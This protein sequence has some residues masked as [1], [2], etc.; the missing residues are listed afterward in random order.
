MG[1][2][3][4]WMLN[5]LMLITIAVVEKQLWAGFQSLMNEEE[6]EASRGWLVR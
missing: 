5:P 3:A 1:E 2:V 6:E 4:P